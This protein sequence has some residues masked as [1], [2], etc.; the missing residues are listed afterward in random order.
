MKRIILTGSEGLIGKSLYSHLSL[1]HDVF[2]IDYLKGDDLSNPEYVNDIFKKEKGDV[3]INC[4]AKNHHIDKDGNSSNRF[5]DISL[6]SF[7]Q[8]LNAN[9]TSLFSVC[10]EY[11]RNNK[12]GNIINFGSLYS[13]VSPRKDLY[14]GDE[15]HIG[16]SVSKAG[17]IMLTK[18]I[19]THFSPNFRANTIILGGVSYNQSEGFKDLYNKNVPMGRMMD[20]SEVNSAVDFAINNTYINGSEIIVDGGWT[21]I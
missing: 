2:C 6:D 1:N 3:L 4:F 12:E 19:A 8:Y 5:M 11:I 21:A 10:R 20:V 7:N 15:K 14:N 18:H 9:L 17:V 13:I 16:Y